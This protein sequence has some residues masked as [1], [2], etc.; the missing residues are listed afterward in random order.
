M[1]NQIIG[2]SVG[3]LVL[4]F[5][6]LTK[7]KRINLQELSLFLFFVFKQA[8]SYRYQPVWTKY[9]R[10]FCTSLFIIVKP[11]SDLS[12][13]QD[14]LS[15]SQCISALRWGHAVVTEQHSFVDKMT[16]LQDEC[17]FIFE[18]QLIYSVVLVS[19]VHQSDSVIYIYTHTHTHTHTH[20]CIWVAQIAKNLPVMWETQ[21]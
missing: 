15:K 19:A 13:H 12:V 10:S 8:L 11:Q 20:R 2:S 16:L 1:L 21:A 5:F 17:M 4:K 14:F 18:V 7:K 9:V 6:S 3:L